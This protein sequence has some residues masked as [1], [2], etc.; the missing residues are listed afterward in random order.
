MNLPE[1]PIVRKL[2]SLRLESGDFVIAGSGPLLAHGLRRTV[3]DLDVV[4]RGEAWKAATELSAPVCAPSGHGSMVVLFG[5]D[6]EVFDRWLPGTVGADELIDGAE[7]VQG[8]PF[9]PLDV[10]LGWKERSSRTKDREDALLIRKHL[11]GDTTD[12]G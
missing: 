8:L 9:C 2:M 5:G 10:V 12:L 1:H 6:L 11:G 4:A 7:W 3:G